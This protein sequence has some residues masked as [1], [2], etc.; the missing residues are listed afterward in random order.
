M[1]ED[2]PPLPRSFRY[3]VLT[4][5]GEGFGVSLARTIMP[6]LAVSVL[7]L[8]TGYVGVLK[9]Q[10]TWELFFRSEFLSA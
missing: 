7:G 2:L 6:I 4:R 9:T 10:S 8:G 3:L 1:S 5:A